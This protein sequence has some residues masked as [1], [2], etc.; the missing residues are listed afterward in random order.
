MQALTLSATLIVG[1]NI[2]EVTPLVKIITLPTL[3]LTPS[4]T[5]LFMLLVCLMGLT[6]QQA[7][8]ILLGCISLCEHCS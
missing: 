4:Y 8:Y 2:F 6:L 1:G 7:Q 3:Q 5:G